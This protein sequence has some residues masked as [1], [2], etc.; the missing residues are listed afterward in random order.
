MS[1]FALLVAFGG[2]VFGA[3]IGALPAFIMVGFLVLV[4]V[5]VQ[6]ATG[7]ADFF[8][9]PFGAFGP[10]VGGFA[11]GVAAVA[12]ATN[13]GKFEN[14]RDITA[15][16]MGLN[17]P[18]VLFI[19]G[20]F[21]IVG[22]LINWAFGL[23]GVPWTDSVALTVVVSAVIA[24][25]LWGKSGVFGEVVDGESRYAPSEAYCW[26]PWQS[27]PGQNLLIGLGGGLFSAH[28]AI[29]LGPAGAV[30]GFGFSAASLVFLQFGTKVPVTHH[31]TL[32]AAV[33]AAASGSYI[34]GALFGLI[35][36]FVG[37]LMANTFCAWGDTHIDPPAATIALLTSLS[38]LVQ[39][40]GVYGLIVL[41]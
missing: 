5:A 40:L 24:R 8:G 1:F 6:L 15:G 31:I 38:L 10:H 26:V 25:L 18:D 35:A 11:S 22:Y 30:L 36:A 14:A 27:K 9:I 41:F 7:N 23:V 37:E 13:R 12:Y 28:L 19:G 2:G 34:W 4:G 16:M 33:A 3:A 29:V 17:S 21:G 39:A 20:L 32:V